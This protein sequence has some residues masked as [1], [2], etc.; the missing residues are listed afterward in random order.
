M[1]GQ[2]VSSGERGRKKEKR[3]TGEKT[4]TLSYQG[5]SFSLGKLAASFFFF[6]GILFSCSG[7]VFFLLAGGWLNFLLGS[8][9]VFFRERTRR[10][11]KREGEE[12]EEEREK[13]LEKDKKGGTQGAH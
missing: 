10:R 5:W 7:L 13:L 2:P 3:K 1:G 11:Y 8:L 6:W 12:S 9:D 4:R